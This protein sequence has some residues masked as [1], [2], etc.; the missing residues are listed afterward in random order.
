MKA[1]RFLRISIATIVA[2]ATTLSSFLTG[3]INKAKT[4]ESTQKNVIC[5]PPHPPPEVCDPV[6]VPPTQKP[7]LFEEGK[8]GLSPEAQAELDKV[9]AQM[10]DHP[11]D[12]VTLEG[13]ANDANNRETNITLG[14]QRAKAAQAYLVKRG[15]ASNRIRVKSAG[16]T[17]P[18]APNDSPSN[19]KL[20][21][22]V[23]VDFTN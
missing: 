21:R 18:I 1:V 10:K 8:T 22:C 9:C 19:K 16:D 6:L 2:L 14:E 3:C 12:I 11:K 15:I 20:N 7:I 23:R 5:D 4:P 13:H 17:R